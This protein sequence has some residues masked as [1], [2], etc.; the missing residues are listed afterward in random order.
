MG[1]QRNNSG[2]FSIGSTD[3]ISSAQANSG[4]GKK[5]QRVIVTNLGLTLC[6]TWPALALAQST[7]PEIKVSAEAD[8]GYVAKQSIT[9]TRTST[10]LRD[11]PQAIS[12]VSEAQ[13]RDQGA[14][15][16]Q[17]ALRYVPGVGFAQGEG[18]R[19]TPIFRGISSTGDFFIDGIRDDVQYYRDLYNIDSVEV[20]RGPNA[21][22][23]GS[24]ATGGLINRV[25]RVPDWTRSFA[26]SLTYG[27]W[28]NRRATF[29]LNQPLNDKFSFRLN[30]MH[31]NSNSYRDGVSIERSGINP[32]LTWRI[33]PKTTVTVGYEYFNDKRIADRGITSYLG[34]PVATGRSTFFGNADASPTSTTLNAAT[35]LIEHTFDNG[36]LLRNRSRYADQD[37]FYQNVFPGAVAANGSTVSIA[38]YNNAS[39]RESWF[40]Q[41]DLIFTAMTG[42]SGTGCWPAW[43][44]AVRIPA[45]SA[46]PA[47][48]TIAPPASAYRFR[49]PSRSRRL[50]SARPVAMPT[51]AARPRSPHCTCRT[52]SS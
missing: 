8:S 44:S 35:A 37:K 25:S 47:F 20:F 50:P 5:R 3:N 15:S 31:E 22:I 17:E 40:N 43:K 39:T 14:Q 27:S 26:A 11:T 38:A 29:D 52:R 28:D 36:T 10:A 7:L 6:A 49:I 48:S 18:N 23:F 9:A 46:A 30:G 41:T 16:L 13:V 42:A 51:T 21:M 12:V 19:E 24:G 2:I 32:T 34:A 33:A 45:I 4:A 1:V